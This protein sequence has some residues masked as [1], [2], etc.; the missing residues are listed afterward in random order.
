MPV[1]ILEAGKW[2][3]VVKHNM[4]IDYQV[5]IETFSI[6]QKT[7]DETMDRLTKRHG[8]TIYTPTPAEYTQW[9][10]VRETVWQE[11]AEQQKGKIDL[12]MAKRLYESQ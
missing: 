10:S 3:E 4:R 6:S 7:L 5:L 2:Y 9:A 12:D 1:T 11:V 8:M